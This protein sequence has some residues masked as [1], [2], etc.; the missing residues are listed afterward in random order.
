MPMARVPWGGDQLNIDLPELWEIQQVA[1]PEFRPSSENWV[2]RLAV[3]L[4]QPG[5]GMPLGRLLAARRAGRIV[6]IVEDLTRHSP[7]GRILSV[8]MREIRHAG[9]DNDQVEIF[10]ATGTHP[11][12]TEEQAEEKLGPAA[13]GIQR[14]SNPWNDKSCYVRVGAV[15]KVP[16][17]I[18]RG[19]AEADL[20]IIISSVSPHLQAGYG[21]G[22][23]MLLPGASHV[24]TVGG[25]H[26]LGITRAMRQLVGLAASHNPMR[27]A[28]DAGGELMDRAGGKSFAIQYL[29]DDDNEVAFL[30]TGEPAATH[31][32]VAKQCAVACGIVVPGPADVLITNAHP[33]DFDLWQCFKCIPNTMWAVRPGGVI[34]CLARCEAGLYG[35]KVPRWPLSPAWMRR[36]VRLLGPV[37]L[38]SLITRL[39]PSLA[40]DAAFFV[41]LALQMLHRNPIFMVSPILHEAGV[42]FPGLELFASVDQAVAAA[43]ELLGGGPQRVVIFPAGGTTFPIPSVPASR[44]LEV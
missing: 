41:R 8:V 19:V 15:S 5:T 42:N 36:L 26:R 17:W 29:L 40:G 1:E 31:Q 11:P 38:A 34:V 14:R 6:L 24:E 30:A 3:A 22:Y 25:L 4:D 32:M 18:D 37:A 35:M 20:R 21:G 39:V 23:K 12:L 44:R 33:R 7:L 43:D 10:F 28:I 13:E 16:V 9:I 2:D 27:A